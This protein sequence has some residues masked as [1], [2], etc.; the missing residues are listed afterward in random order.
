M[1]SGVVPEEC[2]PVVELVREFHRAFG[3]P[4]RTTSELGSPAEVHLRS[5]LLQ[6]E[7]GE[8]VAALVDGDRTAVAHELAD[9]VSVAYGTALQFG[10][11][12]DAAVRA[13]H[14]ATMSKLGEDGR[15]LRKEDGKVVKGPRL[16]PADVSPA[17]RSPDAR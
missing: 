11:D 1:D 10:I 4:L 9:V 6:E 5:G 12:L 13:L 8:A 17:L 7:C 16:R 3:L 15:A 14:A 2:Q